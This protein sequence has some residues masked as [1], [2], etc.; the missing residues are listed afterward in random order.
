MWPYARVRAELLRRRSLARTIAI[1]TTDGTDL[2]RDAA[3]LAWAVRAAAR[4]VPRASCLTQALALDALMAV[5]NHRAAIRLGVARRRDGTFEAHAWVEHE[6]KVLIGGRRDLER[7]SVLP[8]DAS[9]L[10]L[11]TR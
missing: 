2:A 9:P 1:L 8:S 11:E 3:A 5:A 6:G 10:G 7:F 4:R